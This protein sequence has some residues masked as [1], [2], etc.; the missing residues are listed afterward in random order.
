MDEHNV[1]SGKLSTAPSVN[2]ASSSSA[3]LSEE[4]AE[5]PDGQDDKS[6]QTPS[7]IADENEAKVEHP[8]DSFSKWKWRAMMALIFLMASAYGMMLLSSLPHWILSR[9]RLDGESKTD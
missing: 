1:V 2:M 5:I 7:V 4:R 6:S 9:W 8:R 3:T